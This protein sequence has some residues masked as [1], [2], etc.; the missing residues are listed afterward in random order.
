MI[1]KFAYLF[2]VK[3]IW[4]FLKV[5]LTSFQLCDKI[6]KDYILITVCDN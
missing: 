4:L 1:K 2:K 3:K 6:A 5:S